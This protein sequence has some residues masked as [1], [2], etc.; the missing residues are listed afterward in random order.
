MTDLD[1]GNPAATATGPP[2]SPNGS[3]QAPAPAMPTARRRR[4]TR[5]S[6]LHAGLLVAAGLL[7]LL[8]IFILENTHAV[9]VGFLGAHLRVSLAVA[10]LL[11]AVAGA[12]LVGVAGAARITQ[13]RRAVRRAVHRVDQPH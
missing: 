4:V 13:L 6:S 12:L 7:V 3:V 5:L 10:M 9:N 2:P 1:A 11:A 8:L